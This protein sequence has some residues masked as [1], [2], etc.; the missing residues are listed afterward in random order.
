[1]DSFVLNRR[2]FLIKSAQLGLTSSVLSVSNVVRASGVNHS[3]EK[4]LK[5]F[6]IVQGVTTETETQ[7][8]ID[9][10]EDMKI[11]VSLFDPSSALYIEPS[12]VD[13]TP[14]SVIP[15]SVHYF[16]FTGLNLGQA[17]YLHV[18]DQEM[19]LIDERELKTLDLNMEKP[20]IGFV[21]CAHDTF[22]NYEIWS[23]LISNQP[24]LMIFMGDNVYGD[25]LVLPSPKNLIRRYVEARSRIS[26]Y[27]LK[28]LIPVI[29]IWDD[30]DYGKN[31]ADGEYSHKDSSLATFNTFFPRRTVD[32][33]FSRGPG[34]S[35]FYRAFGCQFLLLDD[36]YFRSDKRDKRGLMF[37]SDQT[38]WAFARIEEF[39]GP[40]W[41]IQGNQTFG[42]YNGEES[43]EGI[44]RS[45]FDQFLQRLKASQKR[46]CFAGGDVH[47]SETMTIE[48][49]ILGYETF[50]LT[51]SSVHSSSGG[52]LMQNPRR[53][54]STTK[55]NFILAS[56]SFQ[57]DQLAISVQSLNKSGNLMF[58]DILKI[59]L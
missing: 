6:A 26:F 27:R 13:V 47:Y 33:V 1:M 32:G 44:F 4:L 21:S 52:F 53:R 22:D 34:A 36:R 48:E 39:E 55:R 15:W 29:A 11:K 8:T 38:N 5:P 45:D 24:D 51:S 3:S 16:R 25:F 49:H 28:K 9:V 56:S 2:Q 35:S 50:E 20:V 59:D 57:N 41:I 30:H 37:G 42:A 14:L 31:N 54:K 43:Y 18:F 23:T 46:V 12:I 10:P 7:I 40:T 17:Y 19:R 58:N